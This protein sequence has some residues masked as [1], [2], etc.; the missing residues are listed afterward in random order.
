MP[1][2]SNCVFEVML[3]MSIAILKVQRTSRQALACGLFLN[4][5]EYNRQED[6]YRLLVKPSTT[7]KIHPASRLSRV[8]F[9]L[10]VHSN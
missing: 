4:V 2:Y 5:C 8:S 6:R 1:L 7:L 3:F 9:N 10:V